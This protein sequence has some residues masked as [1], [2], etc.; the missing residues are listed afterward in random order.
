MLTDAVQFISMFG[1]VFAV[2]ILGLLNMDDPWKLLT[3]AD[4]GERLILFE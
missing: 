2:I 4:R 3:I 1:A